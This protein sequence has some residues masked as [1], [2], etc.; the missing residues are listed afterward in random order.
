MRRSVILVVV[1]CLVLIVGGTVLFVWP[2]VASVIAHHQHSY[3]DAIIN[4]LLTPP[5]QGTFQQY[6]PYILLGIVVVM[7][8]AMS[9]HL[10][11]RTSTTHGSA[12][13]ARRKEAK[14]YAF[15]RGNVFRNVFRWPTR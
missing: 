1:A 8:G 9:Y 13:H 10:K 3:S 11:H 7:Y 15:P 14:A 12:R 4:Q 6:W 2:S 5:P